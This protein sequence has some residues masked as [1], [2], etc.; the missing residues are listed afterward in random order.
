MTARC[1][2]T[3][4]SKSR[5]WHV[6]TITAGASFEHNGYSTTG[7]DLP[8]YIVCMMSATDQSDKLPGFYKLLLLFKFSSYIGW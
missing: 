3:A 8:Q 1:S 5:S 6:Y 4:Q 7:L 2:T